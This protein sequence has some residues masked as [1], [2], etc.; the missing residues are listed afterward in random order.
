MEWKRIVF[1]LLDFPDVENFLGI[2]SAEEVGRSQE[3]RPIYCL[4]LG[5]GSLRLLIVAGIHGTEPAPVNACL[6]LPLLLKRRY[7]LGFN[8]ERLRETELHIVPLA[9][10]DGFARNYRYFAERGFSPHWSHVWE[11]A[12][13][14]SC[15]ED[16]NCDWMR[17]ALPETR[18]LHRVFNEVDPHVVLDLHEFYAKGGC[19]PRWAEETEGFR[20]TLTDTP[21]RWVNGA[22][23]EASGSLAEA[24]AARLDWEPRMRH[25]TGGASEDFLAAPT[26][27]GTHFP[28]EGAAKVLV[29]TW[30]VALGSYLLSDRITIHLEAI[31]AT[32]EFMEEHR[33]ELIA[34][35]AEWRA[36]EE[37]IGR[38][39]RG[40]LVRGA[41]LEGAGELLSLHGI[42]WERCEEGIFVPMPQERSRM[43]LLLLDGDCEHNRLLASRHKGPYTIDRLLRVE[44]EVVR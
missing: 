6:L 43:A 26:C 42:V 19:P 20:A 22:I 12:R 34:M 2:C 8:F 9:N 14:T 4:R 33:D 39:Y 27:L 23:K 31:L 1:N 25:F 35:K 40:F 29:E 28:Y 10:P 7:P 17:L 15:G 3:G 36:E 30:G 44:V 18:A 38:P 21:Y 37:T 32:L 13:F 24:I 41:E 5:S 11:D 16:I